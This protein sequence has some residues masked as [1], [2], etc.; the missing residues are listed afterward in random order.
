MA[1]GAAGA[2]APPGPAMPVI[3]TARSTGA[4]A[5]APSAIASATSGL[6]APC[7]R[8]ICAGTPSSSIFAAFE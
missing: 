3:E 4:W 2:V 5:R 1:L 8:I 6:T 7:A